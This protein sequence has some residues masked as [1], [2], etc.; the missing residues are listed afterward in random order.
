[1]GKNLIF[2]FLDL[3]LQKD[4]RLICGVEFIPVIAVTDISFYWQSY[5]R[6]NK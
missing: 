2:F 4:M 6:V 5:I 3:E 1:M